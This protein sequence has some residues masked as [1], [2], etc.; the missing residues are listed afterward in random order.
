VFL[1]RADTQIQLGRD[2]F[3]HL[4]CGNQ[5]GD[6][7]FPLRKRNFER[8]TRDG[9]A[10]SAATFC[11]HAAGKKH[12]A[13]AHGFH[14]AEDILDGLGLIDVPVHAENHQIS[15]KPFARMS[16]DD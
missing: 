1:H 8:G 4:T 9:E 13:T 11:P 7:L 12:S 3:G 16:G 15:R 5:P 14:R 10:G 2:L 6:L